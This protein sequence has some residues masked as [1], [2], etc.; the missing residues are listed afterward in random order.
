MT[1]ISSS[2]VFD[3]FSI[4]PAAIGLPMK[5]NLQSYLNKQQTESLDLD[6]SGSNNSSDTGFLDNDNLKTLPE[7]IVNNNDF[8][9]RD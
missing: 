4:I 8:L 2:V 7:T 5:I 9:K 1:T 6:N 3:A